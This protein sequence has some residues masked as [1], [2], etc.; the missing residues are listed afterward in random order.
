MV[1]KN[2]RQ[3]S[4]ADSKLIIQSNCTLY[5]GLKIKMY[6]WKKLITKLEHGSINLGKMMLCSLHFF[7]YIWNK[8]KLY[9][10]FFTFTSYITLV[11]C[12]WIFFIDLFLIN[13]FTN[14]IRFW[15]LN[16]EF[17]FLIFSIYQIINK[18]HIFRKKI[19]F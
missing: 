9:I 2:S 12:L 19:F 11:L 13:L 1:G 3:N 7:H 18:V 6:S 16:F 15:I 17:W 4:G 5:L 14:L 8:I 10:H